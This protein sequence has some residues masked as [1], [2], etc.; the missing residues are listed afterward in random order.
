MTVRKEYEELVRS[1]VHEL[2][3]RDLPGGIT[4]EKDFEQSFVEPVCTEVLRPGLCVATHPWGD[5]AKAESA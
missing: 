3:H 2:Q 1:V 4:D 5:P